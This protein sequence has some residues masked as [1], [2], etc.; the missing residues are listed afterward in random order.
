MTPGSGR[1]LER[2]SEAKQSAI[3]VLHLWAQR[4]TDGNRQ[5]P[6]SETDPYL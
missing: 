1:A 2:E 6:I 3:S 4:E 5:I